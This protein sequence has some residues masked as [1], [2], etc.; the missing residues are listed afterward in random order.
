MFPIADVRGRVVGFGGRAL[1]E[2][3]Q[4][5]YLNSAEGELFHKGDH[6]FALDVARSQVKSEAIVAEGYMD[7]LALHQ[8]GLRNSVGVMG[9]ALTERQV[10]ELSRVTPRVALALD[11]DAAGKEAMLRAARVAEGRELELR[12][13]PMEAG[14]DPAD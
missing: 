2:D 5:K 8:A 10:E 6:L 12:V 7:V 13:V 9:T 4:P 11:A 1:G 14:T 3:Q